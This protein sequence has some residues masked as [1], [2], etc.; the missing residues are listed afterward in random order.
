MML[1]SLPVER[2]MTGVPVLSPDDPL[3]KAVAL[4]R[5]ARTSALP[6][7]QD[8]R[9]VGVVAESDI[10]RLLQQDDPY[11][12]QYLPVSAAMAQEPLAV[13]PFT[14]TTHALQM[15]QQYGLSSL[16]VVSQDGE[17]L[18]TVL[19][20]DVLALTCDTIRPPLVGGM[21]TPLGVYLTGGGVRAGA[22]DLGLFLTGVLLMALNLVAMLLVYSGSQWIQQRTGFPLYAMLLSPAASFLDWQDWVGAAL[23][24]MPIA[25]FLLLVRLSPIAGVH[26]AEHMTVHAIERGEPLELEY[27]RRMPRVHPR[28]G[29]NLAAGA[30]VFLT[31]ANLNTGI[32]QDVTLLLAFVTTLLVW[33]PVGNLL[34]ALFTTRTPSDRQLRNAIEAGKQLLHRYQ[35]QGYRPLTFRERVWNMG[36]LQIA[37]GMLVVWWALSAIGFQLG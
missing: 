12:Q 23:R 15:M 27:V 5:A 37:A 26:A 7:V 25:L 8:G 31:L 17:Y 19:R 36:I 24:A 9:L 6:V 34:Q 33:R 11:R 30:L 2:Y 29:T 13:L 1:W 32:Y 16:P 14:P 18:G 22:G 10:A 20:S 21:A 3:A 4:I 35:L 28:C